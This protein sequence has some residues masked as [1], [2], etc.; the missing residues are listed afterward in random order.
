[1]KIKQEYVLKK[2]GDELI[3]VPI[4]DEAIRFNGIITVNKTAAFM[5]EQ[6]QEKDLS[7]TELIQTVL[8]R[9]EIDE[10]T[11][12]RDVDSFLKK[13]QKSNLLDE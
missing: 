10:A 3:I 7:T 1:M 2:I 5:F 4:K 11:V 6:L 8:D 9:Y 12:K 13:C